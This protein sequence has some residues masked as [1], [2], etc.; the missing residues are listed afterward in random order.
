MERAHSQ[1]MTLT[2]FV[3]EKV[4]DGKLPDSLEQALHERLAEAQGSLLTDAREVLE[5]LVE[6]KVESLLPGVSASVLEE[7]RYV[8][9]NEVR[10]EV[11]KIE[12]RLAEEIRSQSSYDPDLYQP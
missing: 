4:E 8:V 2:A 3:I 7:L 1:R 9:L 11:A 6:E 12:Q 5:P 10:S